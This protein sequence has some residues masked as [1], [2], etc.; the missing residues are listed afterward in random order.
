[1]LFPADSCVIRFIKISKN[2]ST[3]YTP[4]TCK[5]LFPA[6]R[7]HRYGDASHQLISSYWEAAGIRI[8]WI[9][10]P[11]VR[12]SS[13]HCRTGVTSCRAGASRATS[14]VPPA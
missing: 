3:Y 4:G 1:M 14:Y 8:C 13:G 7:T 12:E 9:P 5:T 6:S 10:G 11:P 2:M